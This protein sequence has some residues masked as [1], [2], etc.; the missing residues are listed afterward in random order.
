MSRNHFRPM[1]P[2]NRLRN[3]SMVPGRSHGPIV[4]NSMMDLTTAVAS[5]FSDTQCRIFNPKCF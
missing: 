3:S 1:T 5:K 2:W 4:A